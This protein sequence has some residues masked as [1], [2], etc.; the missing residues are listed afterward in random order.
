MVQEFI[1]QNY[2]IIEANIV[3]N[4]CVWNGD[5]SQWT[6]PSGSIALVQ[7]TTPAMIWELNTAKTDYELTEIMGAG[8]MGFIW[9]GTAVTTNQTKPII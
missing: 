6:P 5:T 9:D 4:I 7:A 3:V 2:L 1:D 8:G